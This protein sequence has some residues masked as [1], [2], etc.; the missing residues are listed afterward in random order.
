MTLQ[1]SSYA[2]PVLG[3]RLARLIVTVVL[4]AFACVYVLA[5]PFRTGDAPRAVGTV[6][7]TVLLFVSLLAWVLPGAARFRGV[8]L[9]TAQALLACL[10]VLVFGTSVGILAFAAGPLLLASYALPAAAVLAGGV[11]VAVLR[12]PDAAAATDAAIT[13]VLGALVVYGLVRLADRVADLAAARPALTMAAVAQE[14]LRIATELNT[15]IGRGLDAITAG[16]RRALDDPAELDEVLRVA[17]RSLADARAAAAD[18]R[19]RSLAPE[20]T[21]ARALLAAAGIEAEVRTDHEEPLGSAGALLA[22]VLRE[23]VTAVVRQGTATRCAIET[24]ERDGQVRLRVS[25]DGPP[26]AARGEEGLAAA[27]ER[28]EAAGGTLTTGLGAD[29]RFTVE[30]TIAATPRPVS[31]PDPTAYGLS[32]T[33]LAVVVAGFCVKGLLHVPWDAGLPVAVLGMA[34]LAVLQLRWT[35]DAPPRHPYAVLAGQTLLS[36]VPVLWFGTAWLGAAGFLAGTFLVALPIRVGAP[37]VAAAMAATG[38][39][40]AALSQ[41][42]ARIVNYTVSVLVTGLVVYGLVRLAR[43]VRDLR[44]AGAELARAATVQERLRAARDLHDLLGHSLA[45]MLLKCELARRLAGADPARAEA[46]LTEVVAM[47]ERARADLRAAS[48]AGEPELSLEIEA[49]SARSVLTAAGVETRVDLGH[50]P[51][52]APSATVLSAVLR[53][54]V[55]NVLRHSAARH[56]AIVT[57]NEAG[58]VT[59]TVDNDGLDP[60]ARR[61]PPGSGI[62]NLTTRLAAVGGSLTARAD[63]DGGFRLQAR[64]RPD[65]VV[66]G[67]P[68]AG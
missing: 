41:G 52:P 49:E 55:T 31:V 20:A 23:A 50:G 22:T 4:A 24:A 12:F 40:T 33:L 58:L 5:A 8:A 2:R 16:S 10:D 43:L 68:N 25:N 64:L 67:V 29:G 3:P 46:E 54:A 28:V 11:V 36:L 35:A 21:A 53:E 34:L 32:V 60:R 61:E 1:R 37:L 19:S 27:A 63:G 47:A 14:R 17:R 7:V 48:G 57:T 56:C 15:G 26:T 44:A 66:D 38:A 13:P 6:V 65:T 30:A 51:L 39:M 18:F 45:A 42:P 59:L 9:A 62:G